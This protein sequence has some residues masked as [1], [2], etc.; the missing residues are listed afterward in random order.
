MPILMSDAMTDPSTSPKKRPTWKQMSRTKPTMT[1]DRLRNYSLKQ[2]EGKFSV[3]T[4]TFQ[5]RHKTQPPGSEP[6]PRVQNLSQ[7]SGIGTWLS[8]HLP[9]W[10]HLRNRWG[11]CLTSLRSLD[12]TMKPLLSIRKQLRSWT[13]NRKCLVCI[14]G[15]GNDRKF[16]YSQH[17][18]S[19]ED[20]PP[21][22]LN[23]DKDKNRQ[24]AQRSAPHL[25]MI[26]NM[27]KNSEFN[28]KPQIKK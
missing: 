2:P 11:G 14:D 19:S 28:S 1:I 6:R 8:H 26:L 3:N 4:Q 18:H 27:C 9:S 25:H 15:G 7:L 16:R 17:S 12:N 10:T 20:T 23:T 24:M 13:G 22:H 5:K 21:P